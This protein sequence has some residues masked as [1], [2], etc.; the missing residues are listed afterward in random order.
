[1]QSL[2]MRAAAS[3]GQKWVVCLSP[4]VQDEAVLLGHSPVDVFVVVPVEDGQGHEHDGPHRQEG[5][6]D[7]FVV[8]H[9]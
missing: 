6:G 5:D 9:A 3:S 1:M 4:V 2:G 7:G 8:A